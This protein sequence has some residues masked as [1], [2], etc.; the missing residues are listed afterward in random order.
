MNKIYWVKQN[1]TSKI[2]FSNVFSA[3]DYKYPAL[4]P[5]VAIVV[6]PI[7]ALTVIVLLSK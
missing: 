4:L 5:I 1:E 6:L 7:I 3:I 2:G